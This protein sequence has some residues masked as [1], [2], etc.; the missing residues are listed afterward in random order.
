M[1]TFLRLPY[2]V[3]GL[4]LK[5]GDEERGT[6]TRKLTSLSEA[7]K[8]TLLSRTTTGL[9]WTFMVFEKSWLVAVFFSSSSFF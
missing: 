6:Y 3:V 9:D 2:S 7:S 5:I 1:N 4:T 8:S